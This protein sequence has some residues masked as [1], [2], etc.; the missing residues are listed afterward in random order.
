MS[1]S[2][3]VSNVMGSVDCLVDEIKVTRKSSCRWVAGVLCVVRPIK[4]WTLGLVS[5]LVPTMMEF[6]GLDTDYSRSSIEGIT[7]DGV[8]N[9]VSDLER[10]GAATSPQVD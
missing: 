5:L 1:L 8:A 3:D 6:K 7:D 10:S 4:G 2:Q 9:L